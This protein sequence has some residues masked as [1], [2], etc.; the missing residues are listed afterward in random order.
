LH[1]LPAR[2]LWANTGIGNRSTFFVPEYVK[3]LLKKEAFY[4]GNGE[5]M[6][7][8]THI[9]DMVDLFIIPLGKALDGGADAQWGR[10]V[11]I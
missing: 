8:V 11:R 3:V 6:R 10:E 7:A 9:N 5:N 1:H 2:Y 4:L